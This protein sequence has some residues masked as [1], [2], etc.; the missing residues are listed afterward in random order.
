MK[1]V[2]CGWV[3]VGLLV[4]RAGMANAQS[5]Y[6]YT[7]LDVPGSRETIANGINNAGQVVGWYIDANSRAH[8]FLYRDGTYITLD[9]PGSVYSLAYGINDL[10]QIVGSYQRTSLADPQGFL[11]SGG[12]YTTIVPPGATNT[13]SFAAA[14]NNAGQIVGNYGPIPEVQGF[15]LSDGTYTQLHQPG[16]TF[17]AVEA[18]N[19]LG[20]ILGASSLGA[21]LLSGGTYAPL[22]LLGGP[23]GINDLG[24]IIGI[25][26]DGV[27]AFL[28]S[29]G[30]YTLLVVPGSES[31]R[32]SA[33]NND[34]E[35]VG[36]YLGAD[37]TTR[38]GFLA[39]PVPEP[40]TILLLAIGTLGV[41]A[42]VW[43]RRRGGPRG[44]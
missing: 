30:V 19:N 22:N 15:L 18:I 3:V 26:P 37:G 41:V 29:D 42:W 13:R 5:N 4:A 10:G 21:F 1:R 43:Q 11:L 6:A 31:T 35:I 23:S 32:A 14:I 16:S 39:T 7:L 44:T 28:L 17:T 27:D 2:L 33:I 34:S 36:N 25:S 40:S 20:Q 24:Q 12:A 9:P 38:H 8:G